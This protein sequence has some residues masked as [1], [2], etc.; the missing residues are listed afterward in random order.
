MNNAR[1]V[2]NTRRVALVVERHNLLDLADV[3]PSVLVEELVHGVI[4]QVHAAC[5]SKRPINLS[6]KKGTIR[7]K[8]IVAPCTHN[9]AIGIG[10]APV[11]LQAQDKM[12]ILF[13]A[14]ANVAAVEIGS[15]RLSL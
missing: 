6:D 7:E 13:V 5:P 14:K 1:L 15:R 3:S 11:W 2:Q 10:F 4:G 9:N 8:I 12:A